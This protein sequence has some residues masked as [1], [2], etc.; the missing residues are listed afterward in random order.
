MAGRLSGPREVLQANLENELQHDGTGEVIGRDVQD[1]G[2]GG[3]PGAG[4]KVSGNDLLHV[5]F[6][7]VS[8]NFEKVL[9]CTGEELKTK[10]SD[11]LVVNFKASRLFDLALLVCEIL[12]PKP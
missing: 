3:E 6:E 8:R 11:V 12:Q 10:F 5:S 7:S 9:E 4:G 2:D 1:G